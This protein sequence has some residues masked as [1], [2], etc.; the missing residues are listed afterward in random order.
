MRKR[1]ACEGHLRKRRYI[2]LFIF[3][4]NACVGKPPNK[5]NIADGENGPGKKIGLRARNLAIGETD[6]KMN[7][8]TAKRT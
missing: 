4:K 1:G 3:L 2:M 6:P 5:Q 8:R 7:P